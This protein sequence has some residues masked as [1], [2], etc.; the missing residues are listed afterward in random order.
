MIVSFKIIGSNIRSARI[1]A[2]LTQEQAAEKTG[3]STIHF[4]RI[5]R[6]EREPT[7][8][9]LSQIASALHTS[10]YALL[11]GCIL[12]KENHPAIFQSPDPKA[13]EYGEYAL[14]ILD[15][16]RVQIQKFYEELKR[17]E[18]SAPS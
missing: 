13:H 2:R 3:I 14:V 6:G 17:M 15:E 7:I 5:E 10:I 18:D 16:Y 4:G 8:K 1:A 12:D 9:M 11:R